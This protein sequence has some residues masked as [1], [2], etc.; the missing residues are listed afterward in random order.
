MSNLDPAVH[1]TVPDWKIDMHPDG[2]AQSHKAADNIIKDMA[3][4]G[5]LLDFAVYLSPY[6]RTKQTWA[7]MK[8]RFMLKQKTDYC[9]IHSER[10]DPRL[11]EQE[12]SW[13]NGFRLDFIEKQREDF[14][15][16]YYRIPGG[17]S[18]ADVYDRCSM[19]LDTL[20]RDFEKENYPDN[21]IVVSHG[22]TMRVLV[23]RWLHASVEE[24]HTWKNPKNCQ[25]VKLTR[26]EDKHY[27]LVSGMEIR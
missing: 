27:H 3:K 20:Y 23:M 1:D 9:I 25:V 18:G 17:E 5:D 19:F 16:F 6:N 21:V 7:A 4:S 26:Y 22:F 15:P 12:W 24:F 13:Q 14:G 2:Q 8:S 11:R 10:E